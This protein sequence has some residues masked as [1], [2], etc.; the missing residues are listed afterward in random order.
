[1]QNSQNY[2]NPTSTDLPIDITA[3]GRQA[4]TNANHLQPATR[5]GTHLFTPDA[6]IVNEALAAQIRQRQESYVYLFDEVSF[7]FAIDPHIQL[8]STAD[9]LALF[10]QPTNY[11]HITMPQEEE[12]LPIWIFALVLA[13]CAIIGF[14]WAM[15]N[16]AKKK[17]SPHVY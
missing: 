15:T 7:D 5:F 13:A 16:R 17:E 9:S 1:M 12:P 8:L 6:Q 4:N 11:S 2:Y 14:I 3:I 10:S